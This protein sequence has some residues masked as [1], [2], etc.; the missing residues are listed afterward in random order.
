MT[1]YLF[2]CH[3]LGG[4][5]V[6]RVRTS[7]DQIATVLTQDRRSSTRKVVRARKQST[8]IQS[9]SRHMG[10]SSLEHL[11][12]GAARRISPHLY[13]AWSMC[14]YHLEWSTRIHSCCVPSRKSPKSY[15]RLPIISS[16]RRNASI[17]SISGRWKSRIW[18]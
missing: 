13:N 14:Y 9:L 12:T 3:S 18:E 5:I 4:I 2:F 17:S 11:T 16:P 6:K 8:S 10:F 7:L 15:K 1:D